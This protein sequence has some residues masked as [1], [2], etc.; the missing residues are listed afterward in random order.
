VLAEIGAADLPLELV[1]N[2][3]D[4]VDEVGR[5]RLANRFPGAPQV[6]AATGEG[7]ERLRARLAEHFGSRWEL[8]RLLVPYDAGSRLSELY[9]LG[10][11]IEGRED[12]PD[13][14]LVVARLP[15]RELQ[16]FA[17]YLIA[18]A[19]RETA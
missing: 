10:A 16:R 9:S 6:S 2:K 17:P 19:R 8:V 1:L 18:E 4:L 7:L 13:G 5:R 15:R 3:I 11:P 14:V 12:T